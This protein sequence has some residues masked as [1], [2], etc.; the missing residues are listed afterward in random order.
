MLT[1]ACKAAVNSA[2]LHVL[3]G[4]PPAIVHPR[5]VTD[6]FVECISQT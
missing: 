3:K 2:T 6:R 4:L 5:R 1:A